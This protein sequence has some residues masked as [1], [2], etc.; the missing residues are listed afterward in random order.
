MAL[1]IYTFRLKQE[2]DKFF[3]RCHELRLP[4]EELKVSGDLPLRLILF[5][6]SKALFQK[7]KDCNEAFVTAY[8]EYQKEFQSEGIPR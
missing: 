1:G 8:I 2:G 4:W 5:E 7:Y 6:A 3:V